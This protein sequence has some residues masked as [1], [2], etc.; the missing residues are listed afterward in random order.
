MGTVDRAKVVLADAQTSLRQLMEE[1][2]RQHRYA[3]VAEIA[4]LADGL[5]RL[6]IGGGASTPS[7][8]P[9]PGVSPT[10]LVA[11]QPEREPPAREM[12]K[13]EYPRFERDGDKLV[14]IGW[15]KK[16]KD[17]YEHRASREAVIGV[18]RH[19]A[20]R[21]KAGQVFEVENL[22]PVPDS[23]NGEIPAYQV[24]LV[25]AW[26]RSEGAI[27]KK[28]RDGHVL[29]DASIATGGL[30]SLWEGVPNREA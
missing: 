11:A 19:L 28:G 4:G 7:A 9:M 27:E 22:L 12:D 16:H 23:A 20:S 6:L 1:C 10:P 30:D 5:S 13:P 29:R 26:L 17:Q 25:L 8:V 24:Y 15:S 18:A 2:L 21:V 3:E 14:K